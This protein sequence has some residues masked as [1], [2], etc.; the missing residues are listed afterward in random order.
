M[1]QK[2]FKGTV[3]IANDNGRVRL[4]WRYQG[5]R[6]SLSLFHY[7][8]ANLKEAR[9]IAVEIEQDILY[10]QF[11]DTLKKYKQRQEEPEEKLSGKSIVQL[12]EEWTIN[13][14]QM[15]C[16]KHINYY[17]VRSML[18]KWGEVTQSNIHLKL[19][20]ETFSEGVY[21]RRL[22]M[23][24]DFVKWLVKAKI[25]EINPLE[26]ISN[27]RIK[28]AKQPKRKPFTEEEISRILE[29]A[30]NDT[31]KHKKSP[32]KHSHYFPFLYFIFK[33]GVRNAEAVG[34]RIA[35]LDFKEKTIRIEEVLARTIK[36]AHAGARIRKETK[37]GKIRLLPMTPDLEEILQPQCFNRKGDDLVFPSPN[38]LPIDDRMFLRRIFKP[39]LKAL[40]IEERVLYACR[41]TFNSRCIDAGI[42]PVQTA[43]LMGNNPETALR[44]YT[45][46][47]SL[48]KELPKI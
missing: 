29:A 34:L 47:I 16:N 35:N 15:D 42:T 39:I 5:R 41:H 26:D 22:S 13:Y 21:N 30:K 38:M 18:K 20:S 45:H 28:K 43:F 9:K 31:Y 37:N 1:G 19:N 25:W 6:F 7:N 46:Q 11:D 44:N 8:K 2:N 33:T 24:K 3:S 17:S 12:F 10:K 40:G 27:K 14:R 4:R 23:L 36:G 32:H 48:P